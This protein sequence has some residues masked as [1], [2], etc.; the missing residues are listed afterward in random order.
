MK[1]YNEGKERKGKERKEKERSKGRES[2]VKHRE[3]N[4]GKR[5]AKERQLCML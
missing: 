4:E 5:K 1:A 3:G 2:K